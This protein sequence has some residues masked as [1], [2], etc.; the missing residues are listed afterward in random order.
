VEAGSR[1]LAYCRVS[2]QEQGISGL[3]FDA[4]EAAI[5]GYCEPRAWVLTA[6][7]REVASGAKKK[8]RPVL[9]AILDEL[10]PGDVLVVAKADR[11]ARSV[12]AY[13]GLIDRARQ[14]G[15]TIVAT[16]G[17]IDLLT[18]NGRAM[19]AMSAVF[20]ELEAELIGD[21]TKVA[22]AAAK[23]GGKQLGRRPAPLP[24]GVAAK[25]TR[26]RTKG[27]SLRLIADVL[28]HAGIPSPD[29]GRW[30]AATVSRVS[31]RVVRSTAREA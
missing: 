17:S 26:L 23:A 27:E 8:R 7:H 6:V 30:C 10:T 22:L 1:A 3:G 24:Q 21:R 5:R 9:E 16:D 14:E 11:L 18:P 19:S 31:K 15:W 25:I 4:Q 12:S 29:G 13:V 20:G 28:N 2:T